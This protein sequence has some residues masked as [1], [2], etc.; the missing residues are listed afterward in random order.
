MFAAVRYKLFWSWSF[1]EVMVSVTSASSVVTLAAD[2]AFDSLTLEGCDDIAVLEALDDCDAGA[3][4][5]SFLLDSSL[6]VSKS[7]SNSAIKLSFPTAPPRNARGSDPCTWPGRYLTQK[8]IGRA[9]HE[10]SRLAPIGFTSY[11]QTQNEDLY[12]YV[13]RRNRRSRTCTHK[14]TLKHTDTV[15]LPN[16]RTRPN[17]TGIGR[18]LPG[19]IGLLLADKWGHPQVNDNPLCK[20]DRYWKRDPTGAH[21]R[22]R[23]RTRTRRADGQFGVARGSYLSTVALLRSVPPNKRADQRENGMKSHSKFAGE[24]PRAHQRRRP[25]SPRWWFRS[26]ADEG[27]AASCLASVGARRTRPIVLRVK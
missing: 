5:M 16:A 21:L 9:R 1:L 26:V 3:S 22:H 7:D 27:D 11:Q 10:T 25:P 12:G 2:G 18:Q 14:Q 8:Q 20:S 13:V 17:R 23:N 19:R 24:V 4:L 6:R 15:H